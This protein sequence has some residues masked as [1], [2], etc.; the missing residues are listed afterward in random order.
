MN[1]S[2]YSTEAR[3][4]ERIMQGQPGFTLVDYAF[5]DAALTA[6]Q[7]SHSGRGTMNSGFYSWEPL[8]VTQKPE[9]IPRLEETP[10]KDLPDSEKSR[11]ILRGIRN[12]ILQ[13]G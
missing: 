7:A 9:N 11:K 4:V 12:R 5:K 13:I 6:A 1:L 2:Y 3:K 10:P 8:G